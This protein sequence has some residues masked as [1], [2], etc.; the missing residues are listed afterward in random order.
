MYDDTSIPPK[1]GDSAMVA[2]K[3][4]WGSGW[5]MAG[6]ISPNALIGG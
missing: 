4:K 2:I 3:G 1:I 5:G 6:L